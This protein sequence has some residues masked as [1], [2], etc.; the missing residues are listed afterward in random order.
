MLLTCRQISRALAEKDYT[1]LSGYNRFLLKFHVFVCGI[2]GCY[3]KQVM[4][5]QDGLRLYLKYEDEDLESG[6]AE[7]TAA[8][9][10]KM[11]EALRQAAYRSQLT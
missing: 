3:N 5:L 11:R 1:K 9:K 4:S 10:Q 2:C 8:Q 7:L 6:G